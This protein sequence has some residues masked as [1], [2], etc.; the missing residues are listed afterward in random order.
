MENNHDNLSG[1][2]RNVRAGAERTP[3][4]ARERH[5]LT[6][7]ADQLEQE[8]GP[9]LLTRE[10]LLLWLAKQIEG[11]ETAGITD[12]D[13]ATTMIDNAYLELLIDDA[14]LGPLLGSPSVH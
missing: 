8:F 7:L 12:S 13:S 5:R 9:A 10:E 4:E 6:L 2:R 3:A 14:Y 11:I 1:L